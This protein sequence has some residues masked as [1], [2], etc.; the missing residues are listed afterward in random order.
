MPYKDHDTK[1]KHDR[2][3]VRRLT[4][5]AG[6]GLE[7]ERR[8]RKQVKELE[9][10]LEPLRAA[11][12]ARQEEA[13]ALQAAVGRASASRLNFTRR[14]PK[15]GPG[16]PFLFLSDL[17]MNERVASEQIH[18]VNDFSPAIAK[19]RL[20]ECFETAVDLARNHMV[21]PAYVDGI[22]VP[23]GG[24]LFDVLQGRLHRAERLSE[25]RGVEAAEFVANVLEPGFR[26]LADAFG[27]VYSPWVRGN[28]GRLDAKMSFHDQA[29][30]NLDRAVYSILEGRLRHDRRFQFEFAP[31]PRLVF[32]V[33]PGT[34]HE[35]RYLLLHGDEASGM[36]RIGDAEAGFVNTVARGVK[37]L[38]SLH[39]QLGL[40]F[41]TA[42]VGHFHQY[43][44]LPGCIT[45]G[46]LPG[47]NEFAN[48]RA[49]AFDPPR[50][51]FWFHHPKYG[52]TCRWPI[53]VGKNEERRK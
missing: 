44:E 15:K 19:R 12:Q 40:P 32:S 7:R 43:G 38:R 20:E 48:G 9:R 26:L 37:R 8:L 10:E 5:E 30:M 53:Y 1:L 25:P 6:E 27:H 31:G 52:I 50:Q 16:T 4:E 49:F 3:R 36:P 46:S 2:E 45:N 33:Y 21:N 41:D 23:V 18:G 39:M 14:P 11:E 13:A 42:L 47:F 22:V 35:H 29:A 17:H 28:H 24:D 51:A 34:E